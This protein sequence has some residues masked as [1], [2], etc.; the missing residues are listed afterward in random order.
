MKTIAKTTLVA[1][2]AL[3][4]CTASAEAV[5]G[6]EWKGPRYLRAMEA[7]ARVYADGGLVQAPSTGP[8][9]RIVL[10]GECVKGE[11]LASMCEAIRQTAQFPVRV[12]SVKRTMDAKDDPDAV[13]NVYLVSDKGGPALLV[14]PEDSWAVVNV[15][16]LAKDAAGEEQF[17]LRV[18]KELWRALAYAM[19]AADSQIQPCV[20][21]DIKKPSDLDNYKVKVVSPEP[22]HKMMYFASRRGLKPGKRVTYRNAVKEGWAPAPITDIQRKIKENPDVEIPVPQEMLDAI[23]RAS[24]PEDKAD[25][26]KAP[27]K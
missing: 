1:S 13:V 26:A 3:A 25:G 2:L 19:G 14:A 24:R 7:R 17:L 11:A 27:A 4:A 15:A 21:R 10:A 23:I 12:E 6:S 9:I 20:M 5:R 8:T 22:L 16:A 18:E